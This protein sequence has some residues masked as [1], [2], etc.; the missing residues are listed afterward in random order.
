MSY[1]LDKTWSHFLLHLS[2]KPWN[3]KTY[4]GIGEEK[5][6]IQCSEE[7]SGFLRTGEQMVAAPDLQEHNKSRSVPPVS[8][9]LYIPQGTFTYNLPHA[10][11]PGDA[12]KST[13]S[14]TIWIIQ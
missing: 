10:Q 12:E 14:Q 6:S 8:A 7:K 5:N 4:H 2:L 13:Q 9:M 3:S 11:R 1:E